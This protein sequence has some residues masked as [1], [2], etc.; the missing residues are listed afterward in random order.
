MNNAA[1]KAS[2]E[3]DFARQLRGS[4]AVE[5]MKK[6][7][8][9]N[10]YTPGNKTPQ[11]IVLTYLPGES[12]IMYQNN[13]IPLSKIAAIFV[14]KQSN[15]FPGF[16]LKDENL[17]SLR[18]SGSAE[19]IDLEA[20]SLL[21][22]MC[23]LSGFNYLF[24]EA[25]GRG[26]KLG[27][28]SQGLAQD[29]GTTNSVKTPT[30]KASPTKTGTGGTVKTSPAISKLNIG[31]KMPIPMQMPDRSESDNGA[32]AEAAEE[33][34]PKKKIVGVGMGM[35]VPGLV[36]GV[37]MTKAAQQKADREKARKEQ[38][39]REQRGETADM[40][41][42]GSAMS[43]ASDHVAQIPVPLRVAA[44][45]AVQAED[46][47]DNGTPLAQHQQQPQQPQQPQFQPPPQPTFVPPQQPAVFAPA[48][49][50]PAINTTAPPR[51]G[52]PPARPPGIDAGSGSPTDAQQARPGGPPPGSPMAPGSPQGFVPG[53]SPVAGA[54]P[55]G[56]PFA[57]GM[58]PQ[59]QPQQPQQPQQQQQ[60]PMPQQPQPGPAPQ[61]PQQPG[62]APAPA[63]APQAG[64]ACQNYVKKLMGSS[65]K[66]CGQK[67]EAH[68]K[69]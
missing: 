8:V 10:L 64:A 2:Q 61:Q 24:C 65:C 21:Q 53:G 62:G 15:G 5:L 42:T 57:P 36:G 17:F 38:L 56:G 29:Y 39:E 32:A 44:P 35:P 55:P 20:A 47:G 63:P 68:P 16:G 30:T 13:T 6:G 67:K 33:P 60:P 25:E 7:S 11:E 40:E 19:S 31:I 1:L 28:G 26:T 18:I 54:R 37:P 27:A 3:K 46:A 48:G 51:P 14:G 66:N 58:P 23:W 41:S 34:R 4:D 43:S 49:P 50:P 9:F 59:Q 45:V 22:V 12:A 69:A 52:G